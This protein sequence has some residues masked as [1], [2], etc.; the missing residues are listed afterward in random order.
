[1]GA[2]ADATWC[3]DSHGNEFNC[4]NFACRLRD[5]ARLGHVIANRGV[6]LSGKRV[7]SEAWIDEI[8]SWGPLD[9]Q[10]TLGQSEGDALEE[11]SELA[12]VGYKCFMWHLRSDGSLL[13][14][15]GAYGQRVIVHLPTKTVLVQTA[16]TGGHRS[17]HV[18]CFRPAQTTRL[19]SRLAAS[20]GLGRTLEQAACGTTTPLWTRR[21]PGS[22]RRSTN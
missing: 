19:E 5:W 7:V 10:V 4:V 22:W 13:M 9:S 20:S 11:L 15:N 21:A 18:Q 14:F 6:G 8:S 1:M 12:D 17:Q 3:V 2:E 16:V